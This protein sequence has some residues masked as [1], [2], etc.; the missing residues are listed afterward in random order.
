MA[1]RISY[2]PVGEGGAGPAPADFFMIDHLLESRMSSGHPSNGDFY[3]EDVNVYL[4][5]LL[6]CMVG[7]H[8][9]TTGLVVSYDADLFELV[10]NEKDPRVNFRRYRA[11]ADFLLVS[12]GLFAGPGA[13][14]CQSP[15]LGITNESYAGRG[16]AYYGM[17]ASYAREA[18]RGP[19]A[20]GEV[21]EKLSRGFG[22]YVR[23]LSVMKSEYLDLVP[24][25]SEG[26]MYHLRRSVLEEERRAMIPAARDEFLDSYS[27]HRD[28]GTKESLADLRRAATRLREL[29]PSFEFD[30]D[31]MTDGG[32][33]G[34]IG[35]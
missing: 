26:E 8:E 28:E 22:T 33:H 4:A 13:R 34:T 30:M 19:S 2:T 5:G 29:D 12:L 20:I 7:A 24:R 31:G 11:N 10:R 3:D 27:R 14:T 6:T 9:E 16:A 25:L 21:M 35:S 17:A 23:I 32:R 15:A 1:Q 18:F